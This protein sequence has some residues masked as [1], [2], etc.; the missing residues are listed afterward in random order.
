MMIMCVENFVTGKLN[1]PI[2]KRGQIQII[3]FRVIDPSFYSRCV[4]ESEDKGTKLGAKPE[5][6]SCGGDE[7]G[8]GSEQESIRCSRRHAER[9]IIGSSNKKA[10]GIALGYSESAGRIAIRVLRKSIAPLVIRSWKKGEGGGGKG[11]R[12]ARKTTRKVSE[13]GAFPSPPPPPRCLFF[14]SLLSFRFVVQDTARWAS[15]T[16]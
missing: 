4:T 6:S 11:R 3:I 8:D 14:P 9:N 15:V 10:A 1:T 2:M 16:R 12:V 7:G 13:R 5:I